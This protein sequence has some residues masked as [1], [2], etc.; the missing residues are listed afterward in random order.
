MDAFAEAEK[1]ILQAV[2]RENETALQQLEKAQ[3]H[4]A[5]EGKPQERVFGPV[6]YLSRYGFDWVKAVAEAMDVALPA[7]SGEG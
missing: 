5:P 3:L 2:K 1:K 7:E 6:Y 4:I